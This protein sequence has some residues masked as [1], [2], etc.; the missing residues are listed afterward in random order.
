MVKTYWLKWKE[1]KRTYE[2]LFFLWWLLKNTRKKNDNIF[3]S[4][5]R[6]PTIKIYSVVYN[7][8]SSSFKYEHVNITSM[9]TNNIVCN[10]VGRPF[11]SSRLCFFSFSF[12]LGYASLSLLIF[13][14]VS[15]SFFFFCAT[16]MCVCACNNK[17]SSV[18]RARERE[19]HT[20]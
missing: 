17:L 20:Y 10:K 6:Q 9:A 18:C 12:F 16:L 4:S 5:W 1:K 2:D 8:I 3:F 11:R 13:C 7:D 14:F 15:P 19:R